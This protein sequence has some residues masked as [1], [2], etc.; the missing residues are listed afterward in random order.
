[1]LI[2]RIFDGNTSCC[3]YPQLRTR[4]LSDLSV[5]MEGDNGLLN[6][7]PSLKTSI[8]HWALNVPS[9]WLN[10]CPKVRCV[11]DLSS[12]NAFS[13]GWLKLYPNFKTCKARSV[14]SES[15]SGWLKFVPNSRWSIPVTYAAKNPMVCYNILKTS[16]A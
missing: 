1:M 14:Y 10:L 2:A 7:A 5:D 4:N 6:I 8:S 13:S 16:T 3:L 15:S 11:R 9:G 12:H